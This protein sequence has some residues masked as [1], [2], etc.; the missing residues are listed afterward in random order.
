MFHVG[1]SHVEIQGVYLYPECLSI[2]SSKFGRENLYK[3]PQLQLTGW[4]MLI[5]GEMGT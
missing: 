2:L 4:I 5:F 1:V 3:L